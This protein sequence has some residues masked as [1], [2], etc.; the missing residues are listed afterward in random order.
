[1]AHVPTPSC[2]GR[3]FPT[4]SLEE[5]QPKSKDASPSPSTAVVTGP[6]QGE[7]SVTEEQVSGGPLAPH[8]IG[9]GLW[10]RLAVLRKEAGQGAG[11]G[12]SSQGVVKPRLTSK[13][14]TLWAPLPLPVLQNCPGKAQGWAWARPFCQ[15]LI[16]VRAAVL[17]GENSETSQE[18]SRPRR[19]TVDTPNRSIKQ[20]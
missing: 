16:T 6:G 4:L 2:P 1:M 11:E 15:L 5:E 20:N 18:S 14:S 8:L 12:T 19:K 13:F 10:Q 17:P 3:P 9:K 7:K